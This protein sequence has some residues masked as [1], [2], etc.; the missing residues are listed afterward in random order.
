MKLPPALLAALFVVYVLAGAN[1]EEIPGKYIVQLNH[2]SPA[3]REEMKHALRKA[4]LH[5]CSIQNVVS[6]KTKTW[7]TVSCGQLGASA[8]RVKAALTGEVKAELIRVEADQYATASV[9]GD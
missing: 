9:T 8:S 4:E 3:F 7:A 1:A 5:F 6:I 2:A